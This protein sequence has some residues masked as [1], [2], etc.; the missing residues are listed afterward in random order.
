MPLAVCSDVSPADWIVA[1]DV[2]WPRL[3]TFGPA[4]F[5]AYARVRFIPDPTR[6]GQQEHEADL[7]ASPGEVDQ[8]RALLRLLAAGTEDA[9]DCYFGLWEGWGFPESARRWPVFGVPHGARLPAR[10]YFLFHGSLSEAEIW[11]GGEPTNAGIWGPPEFSRGG[12][13]A[14]VWPS[15]HTWC[16]AADIDP[17]WAGVGASVPLIERLIADPRLDAVG[18]DPAAEQPAY[19]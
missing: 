19:R 14:F 2:A 11:G 4:G 1:S 12:A 10:R 9:D 16:V 7:G 3:V 6:E 5:A 15:D 13:P 8:W 17:H 18:A